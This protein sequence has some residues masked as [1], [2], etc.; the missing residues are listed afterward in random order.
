MTSVNT[1]DTVVADDVQ[2]AAADEN[3]EANNNDSK[4][5]DDEPP[6]PLIQSSRLKGYILLL[7]SASL[8]LGALVNIHRKQEEIQGTI[9]AELADVLNWCVVLDDLSSVLNFIVFRSNPED[10]ALMRYAIAAA[11]ITVIIS[12]FVI[13]CYFDLCTILRRKLWPKMF[14]PNKKV[15]LCILSFLVLLWVVTVWFNTNIRGI[16]GE[17]DDQYNIYFTSWLCLWTTFWTLERWFVAS[18]KSSFEKFIRSWP[19]RCPLWFLC[20]IF[21][22]ADFLFVLDA[23]RNWDEGTMSTPYINEMFE[24][25]S[26]HEWAF[27]LD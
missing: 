5:K 24:N 8:N 14:G 19:N 6:K 25:I 13:L 4:D 11:C 17:G 15:E 20:F 22:F 1:T 26:V 16:A 10:Q 27:F 7:V 18:G 21:A 9:R 23:F 2:E 12:G 3:I